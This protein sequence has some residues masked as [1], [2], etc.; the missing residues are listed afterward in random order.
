MGPAII[1]GNKYVA[2]VQCRYCDD[3]FFDI[4][5][6]ENCDEDH[7]FITFDRDYQG[8]RIA[9]KEMKSYV[10]GRGGY[11]HSKKCLDVVSLTIEQVEQLFDVLKKKEKVI[12]KKIDI[13]WKWDKTGDVRFATGDVWSKDES[14]MFISLEINN[15]NNKANLI[16]INFGWKLPPLFSKKDFKDMVKRYIKQKSKLPYDYWSVSLSKTDTENI[17]SALNFIRNSFVLADVGSYYMVNTPEGMPKYECKI[18]DN[19]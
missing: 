9:K 18:N 14:G 4:H 2:R 19:R 16:D 6:D 10:K 8:L 17:L 11:K 3:H 7:L 13:K 5:K 15:I 1:T 12:G